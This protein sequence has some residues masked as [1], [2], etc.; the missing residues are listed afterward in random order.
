MISFLL[1]GIS[2]MMTLILVSFAIALRFVINA[3]VIWAI[4]EKMER[5]DQKG[6]QQAKALH[7]LNSDLWKWITFSKDRLNTRKIMSSK[8]VN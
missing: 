7:K 4:S 3:L 2:I 5:R 1:T 6:L 8:R